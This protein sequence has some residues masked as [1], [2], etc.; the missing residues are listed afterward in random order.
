MYINEFFD[1]SFL[2]IG[3]F[4]IGWGEKRGIFSFV[5]FFRGWRLGVSIWFL[6]F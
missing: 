5:G 1:G 2:R 3:V 6:W 4:I